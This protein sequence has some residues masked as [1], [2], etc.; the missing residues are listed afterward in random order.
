MK[1]Y[2]AIE[3]YKVCVSTH[4]MY[5]IFVEDLPHWYMTPL[6]GLLEHGSPAVL[7]ETWDSEGREPFALDATDDLLSGIIDD[8]RLRK[9]AIAY[10]EKH[11][12][13]LDDAYD[14][15]KEAWRVMQQTPIDVQGTSIRPGQRVRFFHSPGGTRENVVDKGEAI[16]LY[17]GGHGGNSLYLK[18]DRGQTSVTASRIYWV[19]AIE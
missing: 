6:P 1:N 7:N 8:P 10:V 15:A 3:P 2:F 9:C 11:R 5:L 18:T 14:S 16:F 17:Y 19:E 13:A 12:A 4:G